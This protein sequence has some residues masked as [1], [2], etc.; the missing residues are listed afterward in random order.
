MLR[1]T[2]YQITA[3]QPFHSSE[4]QRRRKNVLEAEGS[5]WNRTLTSIKSCLAG[6]LLLALTSLAYSQNY[7][8]GSQPNFQPQLPRQSAA[9]VPTAQPQPTGEFEGGNPFFG[10][11][12]QG[13]ATTEELPV[14][15]TEAIAR[16]LRYNLG[17]LLSDQN[18]RATRG[19]RLVALSR[20]LPNVNARISES[21]QQ[22]SLLSFGLSGVPGIPSIIGPFGVS[23]ARGYVSQSILD[24]HAI[25]QN[26]AAAQ[27][28]KAAEFSSLDAH[29]II[30]LV[31]TNLYLEA[32][33][34]ASRVEAAR[35]QVA[36]AE[37]TYKQAFDYKENGLVPAIDVLRA[38][39]ELQAQQQRLIYF[40]NEFEK[41]KL[42]LERSIGIPDGQALKLT[43][44]VPFA[45]MPS[46]TLE[47]AVGRAL[48]ARRDYQSMA[49]SLRSAELTRKATVAQ[50]LPSLD[51]TGDYGVIGSSL[52][53]SHGT[54]TATVG[55]NF[56]IFQGG[57]VRGEIVEADAVLEQRRA[58]LADLRGRIAAEIRTA[59]LDLSA[60]GE[61][62]QVARKAVELAQQQLTQ[63]QDRFTSGVAN[64]LEVTQA[65]EAVATA[66]ENYISSL[67]AYNAAK[68][69]LGRAIGSAE[70]TI[71]ALFQGVMP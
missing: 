50:R 34:G 28:V 69:T 59:F 12:A 68:A 17:S 63:A 29:D 51:F 64:N 2:L 44:E 19:A 18:T 25:G 43:D 53:N 31:V 21:S 65:Q 27:D 4:P 66:N 70:Q 45:P 33:A 48:G 7:T 41:Q 10:S 26:R 24:F 67:Y 13:T 20:L 6:A 11:I 62:V 16:G 37:A 55:L 54:Y 47:D 60:T 71:P 58:Q 35:A 57:R 5:Q 9:P 30:V 23:D 22:L 15:L 39:V 3:E 46:L 49:A 1:I 52:A 32:I 42:S 61:Q 36:T 14:S 8:V 40:R 56:P 38:Q